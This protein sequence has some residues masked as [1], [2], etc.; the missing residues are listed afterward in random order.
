[1]IFIELICYYNL[2]QIKCTGFPEDILVLYMTEIFLYF[3]LH[4]TCFYRAMC[5]GYILFV[6]EIK[7]IQLFL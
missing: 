2:F 1:M 3:F 4:L 5:P 7:Y 6:L